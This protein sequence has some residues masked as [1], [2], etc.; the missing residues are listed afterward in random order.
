ML[1]THAP[2]PEAVLRQARAGNGRALGEL[3]DLYR[4]YLRLMARLHLD[5]Q[6][7]AKI[8]ASDLVQETFLKA[9]RH[10]GEFRGTTEA[11]FIAWLR[12]ILATTMANVVRHYAGRKRRDVRLEQQLSGALDRSSA[13]FDGQFPIAQSTPSQQAARRERS[14][15]LADA[16]EQLPADY[17]EA[18]ILRHL[19]G[20]DLPRSGPAHGAQ[21]RQREKALARGLARLRELLEEEP[22]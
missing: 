5:R 19:E 4:T 2:D 21:R 14:V 8:D 12:T 6:L 20:L 11:E 9:H 15:L 13:S 3:L 7:Q 16:L 22:A 1:M 10:F 18:V 17:R